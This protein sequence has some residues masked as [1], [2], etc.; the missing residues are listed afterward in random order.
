MKLGA[1]GDNDGC[2]RWF[3]LCVNFQNSHE[4]G[5]YFIASSI[6]FRSLIKATVVLQTVIYHLLPNRFKPNFPEDLWHRYRI[7]TLMCRGPNFLTLDNCLPYRNA[8]RK[9]AT[10]LQ[11]DRAP[12]KQQIEASPRATLYKIQEGRAN[13]CEKGKHVWEINPLVDILLSH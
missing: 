13:L 10:Y 4:A 5:W 8:P 3:F 12:R 2:R 7:F 11:F 1:W 6:V 9:P